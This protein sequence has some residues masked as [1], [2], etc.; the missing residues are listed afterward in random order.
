[1][2]SQRFQNVPLWVGAVLEHL[3]CSQGCEI[4]YATD[5]AWVWFWCRTHLL[6]WDIAGTMYTQK[7]IDLTN[8]AYY[9][10]Q[11]DLIP[12]LL[13]YVGRGP[14]PSASLLPPSVWARLL[15]EDL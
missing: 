11:K 14:V 12:L 8:R 4:Y 6:R 10:N 9:T 13:Q 7:D 2:I 3:S 1:M 5:S 15:E